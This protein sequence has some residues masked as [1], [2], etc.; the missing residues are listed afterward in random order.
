ML[1]SLAERL[2]LWGLFVVQKLKRD[3]RLAVSHAVRYAVRTENPLQVPVEIDVFWSQP[4]SSQ[5]G[6]VDATQFGNIPESTVCRANFKSQ[7]GRE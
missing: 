5:S 2:T 7:G 4:F 6:T 3:S 1:E